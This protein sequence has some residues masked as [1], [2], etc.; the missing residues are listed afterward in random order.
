MSSFPSVISLVMSVS[1]KPGATQLTFIFR[2]PSSLASDLD[3]ASMPAFAA[4]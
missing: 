3:I 2:E 1:I 4:A